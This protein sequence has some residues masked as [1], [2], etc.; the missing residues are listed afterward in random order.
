MSA[1][2]GKFTGVVF[3]GL[4]LFMEAGLK[5]LLCCVFALLVAT[6]S[7]A[8]LKYKGEGAQMT[9]DVSGFPPEYQAKYR[10]M[11][12]KCNNPQCH[13]LERTVIAVKTGVMPISRIIFDKEAAR[14]YGK[15]MMLRQNSG[16]A[17]DEA[18]AIVELLYY[19]VDERSK[20]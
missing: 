11:E 4:L 7:L 6:G 2:I 17:R 14:G 20:P 9:F 12:M 1:D 19:M 10:L 18:K 3:P 16:I 15:K 8:A 5:K 13:T